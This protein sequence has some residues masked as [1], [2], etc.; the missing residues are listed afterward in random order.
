MGVFATRAPQRP[1]PVAL[2]AT[3]VLHLD[4]AAGR[5]AISHI[6]A[7]NGSSTI[8]VKPYTPSLDHVEEPAVPDWCAHWSPCIRG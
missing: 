3:R 7:D 1:T 2:N 4:C 6:D 5:L 8:D